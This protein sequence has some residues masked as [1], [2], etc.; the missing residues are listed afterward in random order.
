MLSFV[1]AR[2]YFCY[3][4]SPPVMA[5]RSVAILG[6]HTK[7]TRA[8]ASRTALLHCD[9]SLLYRPRAVLVED[10]EPPPAKD[11]RARQTSRSAESAMRRSTGSGWTLAPSTPAVQ[12]CSIGAGRSASHA[13]LCSG[14]YCRYR[15]HSVSRTHRDVG[16]V[17]NNSWSSNP[18]GFFCNSSAAAPCQGQFGLVP[19]AASHKRRSTLAADP[20]AER[21][22]CAH[23]MCSRP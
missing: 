3:F 10:I 16:A 9:V 19:E 21:E 1:V 22:A 14:W 20:V 17:P 7:E 15:G 18:A 11:C 23:F 2:A 6:S 4:S 13:A 8:W 12:T 5:F